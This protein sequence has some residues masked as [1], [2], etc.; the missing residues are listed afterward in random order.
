MNYLN[1]DFDNSGAIDNFF[2]GSPDTMVVDHI[3]QAWGTIVF[4][5]CP[6]TRGDLKLPPNIAFQVHLLSQVQA[7]CG[8]D[9]NMFKQITK[10]IKKH[11]AYHCINFATL[12]I[13]SR[14]RVLNKLSKYYN[15]K[16]MQPRLHCIP[17]ADGSVA[18]VP[19][20]NV[21]KNCVLHF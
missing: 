21:E 9:L 12:E 7:H 20:Y 5:S 19:I 17:L 15:L 2:E 10:C 4:E 16:F 18:T 8:N 1:I 11:A 14:R 13:L 3:S 6:F